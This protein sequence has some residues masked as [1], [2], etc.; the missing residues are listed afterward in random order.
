MTEMIDPDSLTVLRHAV[1]QTVGRKEDR[2]LVSGGGRYTDDV[3]FEGLAHAVVVRSPVAHGD[4]AG[5]DAEAARG[6]PG[7]LGVYTAAD[8]ADYKPLPCPMPFKSR[9]GTPLIVP[10]RPVLARDRVRFV[11]E[12]IAL[13]VA[14]TVEQARD[15]A[16]AVVPEIEDRDAVTDVEAALA[17]G[18]PQIAEEAPGNVVLDWAGGDAEAVAA[19]F[20]KAAHVTRLRLVNNRQ[21]VASMEPRGAVAEVADGR[22]ALHLGCQGVYGIRGGIANLMGLEPEQVRVRAYDVGGSFGMKGSVYPEYV[23]LLHAARALGRPVKW[24]D[25]RTE[26]FV[27]DIHGRSSVIDAALALDADG[28]I[29]AARADVIG[30][31]GAYVMG[32]APMIVTNNILK[33][34]PSLY[35]VPA[36]AVATRCAL[37]NTTPISAYRGAGRPEGVYIIDRLMEQA[38]RETGRDPV[39]LRRRNLIRADELPYKA[40]SGLE[41]DS[42]DFEAVLDEALEAADWEGFEARRSVTEAKGLMRGR[43]LACYLE[44]TAPQGKEMGGIRFSDDGRVTI[45]TGTLDYGQG[46]ATAFAQVL[47]D[48][49]GVPFDRIELEQKDSDELLAGGGTGGSRSIMASGTAILEASDEVVAKGKALAG[50]V[51]EAAEADIEFADGTFRIAGTDRAIGIM[52]LAAKARA[53]GLPEGLPDSLDANLVAETPPSAFPNGV[54]VVEVEVD[55]DTGHVHFDRYTVLDDFGTLVNPGLVE[56]QV[57]GGVAQGIGQAVMERVVYDEA[58]NLAAGSF[59]DYALPRAADLPDF[60]LGFHPVPAKT[61]P[62]GVKG[63]GE[64]GVSGALPAVMNA[65]LDALA[66][67]GVTELDMPATPARVWEAIRAA[68]G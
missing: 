46:H 58:G 25:E 56:G 12:P 13:V 62:L 9:D 42:G 4:L 20:E 23:P 24:I 63:C 32:V 28:T 5:I 17:E 36:L 19:A 3:P 45:V 31:M 49:L 21:V 10:E 38:A 15:A 43:G 1:G 40:A 55:P 14:E 66:P 6:M 47:A 11:G 33:N 64:A 54:H 27:S 51:L 22:L 16:E 68:R 60:A 18:A 34:M 29:L 39:E 30:D 61:N 59:M 2:R 65:I 52:E 67:L 48:R 37:T 53:G 50:H 35:R 26:S 57:H 41:Y 8:M 7:V 44:V